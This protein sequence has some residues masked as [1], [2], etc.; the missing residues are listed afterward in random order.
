VED[1]LSNIGIQLT[2]ITNSADFI[3][4]GLSGRTTLELTLE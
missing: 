1:N 4:T 2:T 3:T